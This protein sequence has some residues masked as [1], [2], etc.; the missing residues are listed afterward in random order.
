MQKANQES[1]KDVLIFK[2]RMAPGG[3][4]LGERMQKSLSVKQIESIQS[5]L[6]PRAQ[7]Q[8]VAELKQKRQ[9]K[10]KLRKVAKMPTEDLVREVLRRRSEQR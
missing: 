9:E 5:Q 8:R 2:T 6:P 1:Y 10:N 3:T 4:V 7:N